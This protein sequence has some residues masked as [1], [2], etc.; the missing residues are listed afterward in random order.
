MQQGHFLPTPTWQKR[1]LEKGYKYQE[2]ALELLD[3]QIS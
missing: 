2:G 3:V 1:E